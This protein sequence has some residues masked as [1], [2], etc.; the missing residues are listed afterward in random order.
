MADS[1]TYALIAVSIYF[2]IGWSA[3]IAA[4]NVIDYLLLLTLW[5]VFLVRAIARGR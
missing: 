1:T 3:A 5:P 4:Q 2:L